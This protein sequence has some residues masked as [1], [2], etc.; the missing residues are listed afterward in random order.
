MSKL[1]IFL[2]CIALSIP[3]LCQDSLEN[4]LASQSEFEQWIAAFREAKQKQR[5]TIYPE[6]WNHFQEQA[7]FYERKIQGKLEE[8][9]EAAIRNPQVF[10]LEALKKYYQY[11]TIKSD[12]N[13]NS[14][15]PRGPFSDPMDLDFRDSM[16]MM[17]YILELSN[18]TNKRNN[19]AVYC[20]R[21]GIEYAPRMPG[22]QRM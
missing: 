5:N 3:I 17:Q 13:L 15:P 21:Y 9:N 4:T 18:L 11:L 22:R 19:L 8:Y 2:C 16:M 6:N 1:F 10:C 7:V 20:R 12:P 14:Y